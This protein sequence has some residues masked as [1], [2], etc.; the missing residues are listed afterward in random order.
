MSIPPFNLDRAIDSWRQF[1]LSNQPHIDGDQRDELEN[2][3]RDAFE[4]GLRNGLSKEEAFK[5]ARKSIGDLGRME[6]AY[7]Q[8]YWRAVSQRGSMG[9][10]LVNRIRMGVS[11]TK[12]AVRSARK[13]PLQTSV[14]LVGLSIGLAAC[15]LISVFVWHQ[16][17]YDRFFEDGDR[18]YRIATDYHIDGNQVRSASTVGPLLPVLMESTSEIERGVRLSFGSLEFK[19]DLLEF[20][21][22]A[23]LFADSTF[24]DVLPF[25]LAR[26]DVRT[27]LS[28][29]FGVVL[30]DRMAKKLFGNEDPMGQ[31]LMVD[32]A[33][34]V[35]VTGLLEPLPNRSHL[36]FEVLGS[37][38][39]LELMESWIFTNWWSFYFYSYVLLEEGADPQAVSASITA[40]ARDRADA[41]LIEQDPQYALQLEPLHDIYLSSDRT[42]QAG[43]L[44]NAGLLKVFSVI[45]LLILFIA[46]ANFVNLATALSLGRAREIGIRK[47]VGGDRHQLAR[48]FM[49]ESFLTVFVAASV[50]ALLAVALLPALAILT[51][52]ELGAENIPVREAVLAGLGF[53]IFTAVLAG[54]YPA[55]LMS[56]IPAAPVLSGQLPGRLT[57]GQFR[58]VSIVIQFAISFVLIAA[59]L[60]VNKQLAMLEEHDNG[61][62]QEG[63]MAMDFS[64]DD[65]LGANPLLFKE[66]ILEIAGVESATLTSAIPGDEPLG[67]WNMEFESSSGDLIRTSFPHLLVDQDFLATY[68]IPLIAGRHFRQDIAADN[69]RAL[70]LNETAVL[71]LGFDSPNDVLGMRY[72]AFPDGGEVIGVV[73]DFNF[74]SLRLP[75]GG[76]AMR[77]MEDRFG[78]LTIRADYANPG[79][80]GQLETRWNELNYEKA[81]NLSPLDQVVMAQ[82]EQ[83]RRFGRFFSWAAAGAIFIALMGLF[84]QITTSLRMRSR[85]IGIRRVLGADPVGLTMLLSREVISLTLLASLIGVPTTWLAMNAWLSG[86]TVHVVP[87]VL[88][89]GIAALMTVGIALTTVIGVTAQAARL[90]PVDVLRLD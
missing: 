3:I 28:D 13:R 84:A 20:Q 53:V 40:T 71:E 79:M 5:Q 32:D 11:Y 18:I 22:D 60:L 75:V 19:R 36:T 12:L 41:R 74:R 73:A 58:K 38:A 48:Q 33:I 8:N 50:A 56:R 37:T 54:W 70:I 27:A 23:V 49:S 87:G 90:N 21:S 46:I 69:E 45:G 44:G 63:L 64:N 85:E 16:T 67:D 6:A 52:I 15:M 42:D 24:F 77:Y 81:F 30:T 62:R 9:A 10:E 1:V 59:T 57:K 88:E 2:H 82:Y 80:V 31:T 43:T 17:T 61:F 29:P 39:A 14:N 78:M 51:G 86:F 47:V 89:F 83:D 76:L 7:R 68:D 4:D 35:R 55:R 66:Q 34:E 25:T 65:R 26:G 72:S